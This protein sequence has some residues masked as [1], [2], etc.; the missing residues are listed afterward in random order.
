[1]SMSQL[2]TIY[3]DMDS[4]AAAIADFKAKVTSP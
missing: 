4:M 2:L 1:M 3:H